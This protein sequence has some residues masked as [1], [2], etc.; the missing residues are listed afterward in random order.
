VTFLEVLVVVVVVEVLSWSFDVVFTILNGSRVLV[1]EDVGFDGL[2]VASAAVM[3]FV[4]TV[5]F[6]VAGLV[7]AALVVVVLVVVS[8][9][10]DDLVAIAV[11]VDALVVIVGT[12]GF[13]G[14]LVVVVEGLVVVLDVDLAV[15]LLEG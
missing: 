6:V 5:G 8:V 12:A 13:K 15:C 10:V 2:V 3:G 11:G 14:C 1:D 4:A 7:A 9:G